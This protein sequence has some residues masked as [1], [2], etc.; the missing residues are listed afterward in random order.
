MNDENKPKDAKGVPLARLVLLVFL[1]APD[2]H[3]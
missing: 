1:F 2:R 3:G